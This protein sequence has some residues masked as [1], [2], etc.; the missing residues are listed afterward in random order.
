MV[1]AYPLQKGSTSYEMYLAMK[2]N[3]QVCVQCL[4]SDSS[5]LFS[6]AYYKDRANFFL[7]FVHKVLFKLKIP[8][9]T[10]SINSK[11]SELNCANVDVIF[12]VKGIQIWPSILKKLKEKYN[13]V[14]LVSWS[15]D[16]MYAWHNRSVYYTIGLKYYDLVVTQKSYN[17]EEL[18]RI[19]AKNVLFQNKAYSAFLHKPYQGHQEVDV[20]FIGYFEKERF[21]SVL[22]LADH[23]VIV[24]IYGSKWD[25][26]VGY[27][28]N[29]IIHNADLIGKE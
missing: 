5:N 12:T 22:Y 1:F 23:G 29:L 11:I 16:D 3:T 26:Y 25:R 21:E 7:K 28:K 20:L 27:H 17:V 19:G 4:F 2:N 13:H 10:L 24:N 15:Q 18:R 6:G 9:D 8:V 14:K